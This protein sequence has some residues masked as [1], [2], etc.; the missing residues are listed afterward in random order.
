MLMKRLFS[1]LSS[2]LVLMPFLL[3]WNTA[4]AQQ[5]PEWGGTDWVLSSESIGINMSWWCMNGVGKDCFNT[6]KIL[7]IRVQSDDNTSVITIVQDAI[8][9]ATYLVGTI[10]T[11]VLIYC[12]IMYI[13]A[14][15]WDSWKASNMKK[16]MINAWI[17]ALIVR[18]AYGIV[19]LIQYIAQG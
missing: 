17:W 1:I 4:L 18:C 13:I 6:D 8:L 3:A 16:W 19:R 5:N 14:S 11:L 15:G 2:L 10:L 12:G 7:G 9:A